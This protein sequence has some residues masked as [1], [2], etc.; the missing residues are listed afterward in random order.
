MALPNARMILGSAQRLLRMGATANLVNLL[1][2]QRPVDVAQ[3]LARLPERQA[4]AAFDNLLGAHPAHALEALA[5]LDVSTAS[6]FLVGR[7][8]EDVAK[9]LRQMAPDDSAAIATR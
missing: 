3:L 5:E 6:S 9:L 7:S 2:K 4:R 1:A 8:A